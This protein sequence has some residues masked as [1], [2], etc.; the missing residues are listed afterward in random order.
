MAHGDHGEHGHEHHPHGHAHG[1]S[2]E[3]R[4][5]SPASVAAF[6]VTCS[7]TRDAVHDE[8]GARVRRLL[9]GAGHPI[10]GTAIVKDDAAA[11][12]AALDQA[13]AA[14]ARA[15]IFTGGTGLA[16]RDVTLEALSPLFEKTMPGFG[17]LFRM[18]SFEQVGSA[19]MLSRAAAGVVRGA[20][21]FLLPGSPKAV[22]LAMEKL[23]LPELGHVVREVTR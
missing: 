16:R 15:V 17:E 20:V 8:G 14:G 3:H 19:A 11:I 10:A 9:E 5:A 13:L 22:S 21:V 2:D 1:P 4:A 18:L 12:R 6:V 7:D 23:I